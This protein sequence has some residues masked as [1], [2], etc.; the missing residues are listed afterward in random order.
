[1]KEAWKKW[2][3]ERGRNISVFGADCVWTVMLAFKEH[4]GAHCI[5]A[6]VAQQGQRHDGTE[7]REGTPGQGPG[8][9]WRKRERREKKG[10]RVCVM[11]IVIFVMSGVASS[12]AFGVRYTLFYALSHTLRLHIPVWG[13][14]NYK[15]KA[16]LCKNIY[17]LLWS[18]F[19]LKRSSS[20]IRCEL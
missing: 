14:C 8:E 18:R 9:R 10:E 1:M 20:N 19:L 5:H 3:R 13:K 2:K 17:F 6:W 11:T 16:G 15:S 4:S 7:G 12:H